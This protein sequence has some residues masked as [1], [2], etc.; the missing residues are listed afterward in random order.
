MP[1]QP[2]YLRI[3]A[4]LRARI[5]SGDLPPGAKLPSETALSAQHG[6]SRTVIKWAINSLKG[7]GLVEGRRGSGV[8]VR[9]FARIRRV[10]PGRLARDRWSAGHAIQDA[11]TGARARTVAVEVG[12]QPAPVEV[13]EA[14]G[15]VAGA[16]V[17]TRSRRFT[18][19]GRP[20]QLA[21]SYL[22]LDLAAGTA[23]A[24]I[25]AGPG[26]TYARLADAGHAP[27]RFTERIV[28]RPP[29]PHEATALELASIGAL[30]IDVIRYAYT[31]ADRCVEMTR[32]VLDAAAYELIFEFPA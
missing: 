20:V 32:M 18:V 15:M 10:S 12:E 26:G 11:D 19:D 6:V 30:V 25:D 24:E 2:A 21:T 29:T 16:P 28:A 3:A 31:D 23:L 7:A 13:A 5:A 9:R 17:L 27:A 4:D 22:P 8:Y 14:L 1:G